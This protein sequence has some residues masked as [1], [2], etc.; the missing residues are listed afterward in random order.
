M[1]NRVTFILAAVCTL[2]LST[3]A[4]CVKTFDPAP[5]Q[6]NPIQF[7]AGAG[8]LLLNDD[9]T[10][11]IKES[12]VTDDSFSVFG[13]WVSGD[14]HTTI[15]DGNAVSLRNSG[16]QY[17]N[18]KMWIWNGTSD[19]YDFVAIHPTGKG[20]STV[21]SAN[22]AVS[23]HYDIDTDDYDLLG[24]AYHRSGLADD[25]KAIV[26]LDFHHLGSAI[27]IVIQNNSDSKAVTINS[28]KFKNLM[29]CG[30]A[31]VTL[32]SYGNIFKTWINTERNSQDKRAK[33]VG[34][35]IAAGDSYGTLAQDNVTILPNDYQIM[36][37]QRLDQAV[38]AGNLE[39]NM[40]QLILNYTPAGD[41]AQEY[42]FT[43]KD[44]KRTD[45]SPITSWEIGVKYIY[46]I[47]MRLDG[48]VLVDITTTEWSPVEAQTPGLLI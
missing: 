13:E 36:I 4:G 5:E 40:P 16:W 18:P 32:D 8:S 23:T 39:E 26:D 22:L 3:L 10:K 41:E 38:G 11:A 25:P 31:K 48:G 30:D 7:Q 37:P 20:S 24:A 19:Y 47:S 9:A 35:S 15:F 14:V 34:T 28:W 17:D 1:L 2:A 29:V 43:L 21:T 27:G 45:D 44:V 12:F 42:V 33:T 6:D 46:Y